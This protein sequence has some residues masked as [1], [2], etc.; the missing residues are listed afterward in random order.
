MAKRRLKP[1]LKILELICEKALIL[2]VKAK[3]GRK[4]R[5][6]AGCHNGGERGIRTPEA[7]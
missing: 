5:L 4:S 1:R 3:I 7:F 6:F 2:I